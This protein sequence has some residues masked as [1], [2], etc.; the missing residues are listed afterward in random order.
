MSSKIRGRQGC[1]GCGTEVMARSRKC[2]VSAC[3]ELSQPIDTGT[4]TLPR[5]HRLRAQL[6][7]AAIHAAA[8]ASA[9]ES[10][11]HLMA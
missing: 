4:S 10:Q 6:A 2:S 5:T 3:L 1:K 8:E 11:G 9:M 7:N